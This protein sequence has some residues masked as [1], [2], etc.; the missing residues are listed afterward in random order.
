MCSIL[1]YYNQQ[2]L[3]KIKLLKKSIFKCLQYILY[4]VQLVSVIKVQIITMKTHYLIKKV[5]KFWF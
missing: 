2:L 3:K 5:V 1:K 4:L